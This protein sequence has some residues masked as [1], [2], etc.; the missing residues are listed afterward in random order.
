[1]KLISVREQPALAEKAVT[2]FQQKWASE[3][4]K[5]VYEDCILHCVDAEAPLPQWYLLMEGTEIIG[6]AG[7]I[8]NDFISRMDL[9]PWVCALYIEPKW[10]GAERGAALLARAERD[11]R[12]RALRGCICAPITSDTMNA[13]DSLIRAGDI[14]PGAR[15]RA[16]MKK[17]LKRKD[18]VYNFGITKT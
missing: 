16:S 15:V 6:C 8:T 2:Y 13:T 3:N 1:M 7:L 14:I 12:G 5:M 4:S 17:C 11:A 10:R 9:Y 18:L